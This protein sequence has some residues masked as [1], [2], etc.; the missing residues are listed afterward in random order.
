M[1][2]L[3]FSVHWNPEVGSPVSE[4]MNLLARERTRRQSGKASFSMSFI[5]AARR[6]CGPD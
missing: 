3:V 2:H 5:W 4:G 1:S 6:I